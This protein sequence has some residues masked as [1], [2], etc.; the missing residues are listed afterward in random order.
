MFG[1]A[2]LKIDNYLFVQNPLLCEYFV[3]FYRNNDFIK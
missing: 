1:M 3:E 2:E